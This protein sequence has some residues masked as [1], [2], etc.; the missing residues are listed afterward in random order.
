MYL[1]HEA[2]AA[3][4]REVASLAPG[5]TLAMTFLLPLE[6]ADP[7]VRPGLEMAAKG[8][9]AS[10]TPFISFFMP[11]QIQALAREAGF[12]EAAHVS[13]AELT[14]RYFADRTDACGR[15]ITRKSC[16]PRRSEVLRP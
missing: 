7:D 12:A 8:A 4:L 5:L 6:H 1:T 2:N 3:A 16:W 10:G 14:R 11:A 13:A 9:R 15:R